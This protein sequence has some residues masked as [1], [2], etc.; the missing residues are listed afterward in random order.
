MRLDGCITSLLRDTV[1]YLYNLSVLRLAYQSEM[2]GLNVNVI[3]PLTRCQLSE[4]NDRTSEFI[5]ATNMI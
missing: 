2:Q 3:Y 1:A 4:S 5:S